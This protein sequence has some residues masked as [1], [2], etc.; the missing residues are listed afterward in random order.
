MYKEQDEMIRD[1]IVYGIKNQVVREKLLAEG[2]SLTLKNAV[3][4]CRTHELTQAQLK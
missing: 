2:D 1:K 3:A 4:R